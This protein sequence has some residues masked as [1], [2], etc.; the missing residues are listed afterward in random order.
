M[1]HRHEFRAMGSEMLALVDSDGE[2]CVLQ[3]VP[4]WFEE[5]E[6]VLSRFRHDSELTQLNS[7][8]GTA[9]RVSQTLWAVYKAAV[10]AE[11]LT[12][13]L[14]NPLILDALTEAGYDRSFDLLQ[15]DSLAFA[16]ATV[17]PGYPFRTLDA[18]EI[19]TASAI[20]GDRSTHTLCIPT[21]ARLDFGGVAKGWCADQAV[22][23]LASIG[24]SLVSAGGDIAV[25]GP[26]ANG[27][28]WSIAIDDPLRPGSF[29]EMIYL[30]RGGVATSGKDR[31]RWIHRGVP[32]HHL[33]DPR[34]GFPADTDVLTATVIAASVQECEALAKAVIISGSQ[35]GMAW[36]D[37]DATVAGLLVLE[38]G[39]KLY[40]RNFEKYLQEANE[41][42]T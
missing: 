42:A 3:D 22:K 7:S 13:G 24:P 2:P 38:N 11:Q 20:V 9:R 34:T 32:Q 19:P 6:Q 14:V 8:P 36:L 18:I 12:G 15:A 26:H 21:G 25:S 28:P 39:Q 33:I 27:D 16:P 1:L 41:G 10:E 17:S 37:S 35:A 5:W 31:R 30:E 29:M 4:S 23:R 40:S